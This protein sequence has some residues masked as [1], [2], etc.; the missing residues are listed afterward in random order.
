VHLDIVKVSFIHQLMHKL[1]VLKN[2]TIKIYVKIYIKPAP[3]MYCQTVHHTYT[4]K[5]LKYAATPPPY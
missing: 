3:T 4:N 2:D 5:D 1:V